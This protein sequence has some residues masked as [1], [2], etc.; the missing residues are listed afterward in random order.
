MRILFLNQAFYPDEVATAQ[1]ASDLATALAAEGH[2]VTVL[3]S[4]H[5]YDD[6]TRKFARHELWNRVNVVR[7]GSSSFGK[8]AKWKRAADFASF[9]IACAARLPRLGRFDA[10]IALTTPPLISALGALWKFMSGGRLIS[11]TMDLNPDEAIAAGW[12]NPASK[13]TAILQ[14]IQRFSLRH[15]DSIVVLDSFMRQRLVDG[16]IPTHKIAVVPPWSQDDVAYFDPEGRESFRRRHGW[17]KKF[18]VM[19]S[20]NHSPCHPLDTLVEGARL[21]RGRDDIVFAFVGG[22]SEYRKI[23][24]RMAKEKWANVRC[25]PYQ[26]RESLAQSLSAGDLHA[27]VMGNEFV[28]IVSP[29]K[30]YNILAV[31]APVLYIGPERSHVTELLRTIDHAPGFYLSEHSNVNELVCHI[32]AAKERATPWPDTRC[33]AEIC[34]DSLL[35]LMMQIITR[36]GYPPH[37]VGGMAP[38]GVEIGRKVS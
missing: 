14:G 27:V 35:P 19:Y 29:S 7:V 38:L 4:A 36:D 26:P 30:I 10:I 3:C 21:L 11:W 37:D 32:L 5:G 6:S 12:L 1:Y 17:E 20:G 2:D 24:A 16:G 34:K 9:L 28:G 22:G 13:V 23:Q 31:G 18:V 33:N 8:G 15:S 25:L